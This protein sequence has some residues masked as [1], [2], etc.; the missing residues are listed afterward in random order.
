MGPEMKPVGAPL[1]SDAKCK[2]AIFRSSGTSY[3]GI[4]LHQTLSLASV[5][6]CADL[7]L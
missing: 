3:F 1:G 7:Y 6:L 2:T 4:S 5:D